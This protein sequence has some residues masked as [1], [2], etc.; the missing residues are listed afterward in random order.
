MPTTAAN[1]VNRALVEIGSQTQIVSLTDGSPYANIALQVFD[2]FF[3]FLLRQGD[4]DFSRAASP[5]TV[6][7][8]APPPWTFSYLYPSSAARVRYL[9]QVGFDPLDPQPVHFAVAT[10]AAGQPNKVIWTDVPIAQ[11]IY[12]FETSDTT[13]DQ[14]DAVFQESLVRMLAS[15]FSMG[16]AGRPDY[17]KIMLEWASQFEQIGEGRPY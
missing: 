17:S 10:F 3:S 8:T 12:S 6:S 9:L 15:A 7:G 16:N 1:L 4:W 14:T 11:A 13:L 2:P 5:L